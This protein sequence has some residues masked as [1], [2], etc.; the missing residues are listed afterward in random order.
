MLFLYTD[1]G[2]EGPYVGQMRASIAQAVPGLPAI[3]LCHDLA[4]FNPRAAGGLLAALIPQLPD[5]A[6]VVGVIDP[7]VG[8]HRAPVV[9]EADGRH[10]VGPDNGL[11]SPAAKQA[12]QAVWH[13]LAWRPP[14]MSASFHGRDLFAPAGARLAAGQPLELAPMNTRPVGDDWPLDLAEIVYIDHFGNA[15]TGLSASRFPGQ[16]TL[17]AGNRVIP[18]ART[19]SDVTAGK[20]LCYENSI[21]LMEIAV[22]QGSAVE[23]LGLQVGEKVTVADPADRQQP[24]DDG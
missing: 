16:A 14:G 22:N 4:P 3:D 15:M 21:G 12:R 13:H 19:F 8:S 23:L 6:V 11:F 10:F 7:G 2:L 24:R 17:R 5:N 20:P 9:L 18:R 1:F